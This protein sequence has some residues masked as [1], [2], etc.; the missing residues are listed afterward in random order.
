MAVVGTDITCITR[1]SPQWSGRLVV[2]GDDDDVGAC[3][4]P[5][6]LREVLARGGFGTVHRAEHAVL[7]RPVAVKLMRPEHRFSAETR[8]RFIREGRLTNL[9][10]HPNIVQVTDTGELPDG[11]VWLAMELLLGRDLGQI[12]EAERQLGVAR[13]LALFGPIAA[14]VDAIHAAGIVHRDLKPANIFVDQR[15]DRVVV[16]DFGVAKRLG[17]NEPAVTAVDHVIGTPQCMAPEQVRGQD[18][19][20]RADIY[21]LGVLIHTLLSGL[22]PLGDSPGLLR[23]HLFTCPPSLS[24]QHGLPVAFDDVV[25]RALAKSPA[26]RHPSA[27]A[28]YED[29]RRAARTRRRTPRSS[30]IPTR[31][32]SVTMQLLVASGR[33]PLEQAT[34]ELAVAIGGARDVLERNGF[35][36]AL[37]GTTSLMCVRRLPESSASQRIMRRDVLAMLQELASALAGSG[38]IHANLAAQIG[39]ISFVG[40]VPVAGPLL[41]MAYAIPD[42]IVDGVMATPAVLDGLHDIITTSVEDAPGFARISGDVP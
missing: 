21:A 38:H 14:A 18:V 7:G 37:A 1:R 39:D 13:T 8:L 34:R 3:A 20:A 24:A 6:I 19:D 12:L 17:E 31:A 36:V 23:T 4:G 33:W 35:V 30:A 42:H 40:G 28:L 26:D 9:V 15:G 10:D 29:L 25:Q 32:I 5:F 2:E 11:R 41:R 16:L 22:S 27:T